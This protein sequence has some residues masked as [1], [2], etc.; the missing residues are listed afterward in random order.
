M[1]AH[2]YHHECIPKKMVIRSQFFLDD[3]V[4][5]FSREH[6]AHENSLNWRILYSFRG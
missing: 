1:N 4:I 3:L 6:A 2:I 5:N